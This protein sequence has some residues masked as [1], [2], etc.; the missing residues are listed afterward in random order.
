MKVLVFGDSTPESV[1]KFDVSQLTATLH[2]DFQKGESFSWIENPLSLYIEMYIYTNTQ[3]YTLMHTGIK[4][5]LCS[6]SR[7]CVQLATAKAISHYHEKGNVQRAV[8]KLG[9]YWESSPN[10]RSHPC[11]LFPSKSYLDSP[12]SVLEMQ[13]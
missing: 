5:D 10:Y 2:L 9:S 12:P 6:K 7:M 11:Q 1:R 13:I 3:A 8:F 4:E